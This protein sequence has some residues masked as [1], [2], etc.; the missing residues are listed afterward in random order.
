MMFADPD[1]GVVIANDGSGVRL[2]KAG[3]AHEIGHPTHID[4]QA[5]PFSGSIVVDAIWNY[6]EFH[7]QLVTLYDRLHGTAKVGS[8]GGGGFRLEMTGYGLGGITVSVTAEHDKAT[9]LIFEFDID[10]SYLPHIIRR[11]AREFL[12]I[13]VSA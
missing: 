9:R 6:A 5:G 10:Q 11:I 1:D 3:A 12:D 13:P 7:R 8:F 2:R 4:V